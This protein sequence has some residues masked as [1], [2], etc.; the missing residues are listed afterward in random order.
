VFKLLAWVTHLERVP[1]YFFVMPVLILSHLSSLPSPDLSSLQWG[2]TV[3]IRHT[4]LF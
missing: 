2:P 3:A 4:Q 1:P